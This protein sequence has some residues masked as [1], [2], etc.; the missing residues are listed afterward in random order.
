MKDLPA[1]MRPIGEVAAELGV[2]AHVLRFWESRFPAIAPLKMQGGRR[3]YRAPDVA[4]LRAIAVLS[5]THGM[6]LGGVEK[7]LATRG[8]VSVAAEYGGG[9][10][11]PAADREAQPGLRAARDRLA[12]ALEAWNAA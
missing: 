5:R 11:A 12:A 9:P 10:A 1:P 4:L 3:Y 8:A 6:T 7:L 2:A